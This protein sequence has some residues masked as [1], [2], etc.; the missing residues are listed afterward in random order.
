M[1]GASAQTLSN[2]QKAKDWTTVA[3]VIGVVATAVSYA[4]SRAFLQGV[5]ASSTLGALSVYL[6]GV[7]LVFVCYTSLMN[8]SEWRGGGVSGILN[9]AEGGN[10]HKQQ[11][12][13]LVNGYYDN[14]GEESR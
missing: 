9:S 3:V 2:A 14:F 12:S 4:P 11:V 10:F 1:T 6:A 5:H 7:L 8:V 13:G